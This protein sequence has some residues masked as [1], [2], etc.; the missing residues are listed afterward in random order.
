MIDRQNLFDQPAKNNSRTNDNIQ[1]NLTGQ[2]DDYTTGC[3]IDCPYFKENYE[4]IAIALGNQQ[5]LDADPKAI[6][7][8]N[9]TKKLVEEA[10]IFY[11]Y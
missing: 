8:T 1:K 3:L 11:Y 5:G 9:F 4:M 2:E 7:Q 6:Q 10:T